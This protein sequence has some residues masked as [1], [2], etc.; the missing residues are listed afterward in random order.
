[1]KEL[2]IPV[3]EATSTPGYQNGMRPVLKHIVNLDNIQVKGKILKMVREKAVT[4]KVTSIKHTSNFSNSIGKK[5]ME[6]CVQ[7]MQ[8]LKTSS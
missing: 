2:N 4:H 8:Q 3:H 1:M 6:E 5:K 7:I